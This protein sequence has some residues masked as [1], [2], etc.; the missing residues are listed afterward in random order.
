MDYT[1][2]GRL[3]LEKDIQIPDNDAVLATLI[4]SASRDVDRYC[5]GG[6]PSPASD[7]YFQLSTITGEVI[8]GRL[9]DLG[10][11]VFYLHKPAVASVASLSY[12]TDFAAPFTAVDS[13]LIEVDGSPI[14][15]AHTA[16]ASAP[17]IGW[18]WGNVSP[19]GPK[20]GKIWGLI[21]YTGGLSATEAGFPGDFQEAVVVDAIRI[22]QENKAGI[23]DAIGSADTGV[24]TYT[25]AMPM[26]LARMLM[27]YM[28]MA[29]WRTP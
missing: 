19:V 13:S 5:T 20:P 16:L 11:L 14:V 6:V 28:R 21:T 18:G 8:G 3:K 24:M 23:A 17:L 1:T 7:N 15:T 27:P 22:Y 25:K 26:R 10:N 9:D 2:L 29:P 4:T 12:K